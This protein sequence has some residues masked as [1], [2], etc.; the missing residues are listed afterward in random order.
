MTAARPSPAMR[1]VDF[2]AMLV[3]R[4]QV[5]RERAKELL[6]EVERGAA[7]D[8]LLEEKL[9]LAP[10]EIQKLRRTR[11]GEVPELPGYEIREKLGTGGTADVFRALEKATG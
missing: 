7:L 5:P 8:E 11:C 6:R 1:D 2:L 3:H 10:S 4:G 9:G